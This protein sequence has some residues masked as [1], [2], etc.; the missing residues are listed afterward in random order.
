MSCSEVL[1]MSKKYIFRGE[2]KFVMFRGG[3]ESEGTEGNVQFHIGLFLY[4]ELFYISL[5]KCV[6]FPNGY[7]F[8]ICSCNVF[9]TLLLNI[10][11]DFCVIC[12]KKKYT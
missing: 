9:C 11:Y 1:K 8:L 7:D 6:T 12:N 5:P 3:S 10:C 2:V 4:N